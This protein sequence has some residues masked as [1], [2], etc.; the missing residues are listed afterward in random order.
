MGRQNHFTI[1]KKLNISC[2]A[3]I[4]NL[5]PGRGWALGR[6]V[7]SNLGAAS[8]LLITLH[9]RKKLKDLVK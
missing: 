6:L 2:Q 1:A 8:K 4:G 7:S 3:G 9:Q 5:W